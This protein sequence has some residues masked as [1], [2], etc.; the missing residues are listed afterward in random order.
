LCS[1]FVFS[2]GRRDFK[3]FLG[4]LS[5]CSLQPLARLETVLEIA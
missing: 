1:A 3:A 2:S 5:Q 4:Y